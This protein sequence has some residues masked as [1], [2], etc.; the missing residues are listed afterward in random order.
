MRI[1]EDKI[2]EVRNAADIVEVIAAYVHLK[3]R[4]KNYLGLCPFHTEKTPSFTVSAEKQMYHCF[5]CGKGGNIFT[6]LM[7]MDKVSFVE[8]VRSLASKFGITIPEESKPMTEEQTEFENYYAVCRFAGMHFFKN[9]TE[10]DEGKEAL[11][12][13]YRRGFTDETIRT[14]GLGYAM[15]SWDAFVQKAQEEGFKSE[16]I[17]KVGLARVRD[18]G[19][20]YDYFRGRAMFP[21]FST[22]GRVIGFGARKMRED[23]AIAGK[24]INSPETPIYNKS[25]VLYGLFHAKDSIRQE[26]NALMVEGYADLIS[27]YQAGIQN[28]VASSGTALTEEQLVLI[29]RYSKNLTLVYDADTAGSSATVRGIDLALEHDLNVRIVELPEGDDPDSFVQKHGGNEFRERLL[30]AISFIDF[31]AKQFQREGAFT[32]AEGK[33]QAVRSLVQSIAKMKDE[34]RRNFYVKEVAEKYDVYESVLFHELEQALSQGKRAQRSE[35]YQKSNYAPRQA[36][37]EK[38]AV[39]KTKIIPP[40]ERDILKLILEGNPDVIRFILSNISLLQLSDDRARKLAQRVLDLYDERGTIDAPSIVS[41]VQEPELKNLITDLVLSRYELSP[42]WQEMEKEI[43]V[44][45]PM[46]IAKD[47]VVTVRRKAIQ[48]E[49]EE[50]QHALKEASIRR[51]DATPYLQRQQE[52]LR[53]KKEIESL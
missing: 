30:N 25:R 50:N 19:S 24:Y 4:G 15:N 27:L 9:L 47:A 22:Q 16:D 53:L 21:I 17:A 45:D 33:T 6:F 37:A 26:D 2:D 31:R 52:L 36:G 1:S 49:M 42:Q 5:G 18:D 34:L 39:P 43:D 8:S 23:D 38:P 12:Y 44:P 3:K 7:E 46:M 10:S 40:E 13:F 51:D 29:G 41:E 20:L 32:T 11:Q 28:V 48:K 35:S 14:F